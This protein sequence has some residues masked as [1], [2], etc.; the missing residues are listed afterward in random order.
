MMFPLCFLFGLPAHTVIVSRIAQAL[1]VS[2]LVCSFVFFPSSAF[3]DDLIEEVIVTGE[4]RETSVS[5]LAASVSVLVP[6][7]DGVSVNH[8]EEILGGV[9]NLNS[10]SGGSRARFFSVARYRRAGPVL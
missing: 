5:Q 8:L 4:F 2:L 9:P 10:S 1:R 6:G 3:A 7:Q